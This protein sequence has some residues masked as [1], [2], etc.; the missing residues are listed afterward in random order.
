MEAVAADPAF[1][2]GMSAVDCASA[3][4]HS[5]ALAVL[6]A[7]NT[8]PEGVEARVA[9]VRAALIADTLP[10]AATSAANLQ[11]LVRAAADVAA[12]PS[13]PPAVK[14]AVAGMYGAEVAD[15]GRAAAPGALDRLIIAA[16]SRA[17]THGRADELL[18]AAAAAAAAAVAPD[19]ATTAATTNP[20]VTAA[21]TGLP[22]ALTVVQPHTLY[23]ELQRDTGVTLRRLLHHG[24]RMLPVSNTCAVDPLVFESRRSNNNMTTVIA[25]GA[26]V[27]GGK[28]YYEASVQSRD[29]MQIGWSTDRTVYD[30]GNSSSGVGTEAHSWGWCGYR[31]E[32]YAGR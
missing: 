24:V 18:L 10:P 26:P 11:Q 9:K 14:A 7:R 3:A 30:P 6:T 28:W 5:L 1:A 13:A 23:R 27:R 21:L 25:A 12:D 32:R 29:S 2:S 16:V 8:A 20:E 19:G 15:G 4:A 22:K 31:H 17:H